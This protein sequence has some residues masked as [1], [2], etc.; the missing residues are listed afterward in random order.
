MIKKP[1]KGYLVVASRKPNFYSLAINCIESIKDYYPDAKCCLVTEEKFL[2]GREDIADDLIFCDDHYRAKLWGMANSPYDITMYIDADS[3]IEH[4][5]IATVFDE[6]N[7]K[8]L[9]N[10]LLVNLLQYLRSDLQMTSLNDLVFEFSFQ[11]N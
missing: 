9:R 6:L 8:D 3:E 2:D 1:S 5:D 10:Q 4:E 7:N 11:A